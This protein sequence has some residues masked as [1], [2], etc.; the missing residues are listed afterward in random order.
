MEIMNHIMK[1]REQFQKWLEPF[2]H[3]IEKHIQQ[4]KTKYRRNGLL[5]CFLVIS[6]AG[7]AFFFSSNAWMPDTTPIT[8]SK[9]GESV[10][11]SE[12]ITAEPKR[13]VYS[14]EQKKMEI[15]LEI[16]NI[17]N[18]PDTQLYYSAFEKPQNKMLDVQVMFQEKGILV[19]EVSGISRNFHAL[20]L[21]ISSYAPGSDK[22]LGE[23][24]VSC[25]YR[26]VAKAEITEKDPAGYLSASIQ[27]DIDLLNTQ[28][29]ELTEKI[30]EQEKEISNIDTTIQELEDSKSLK[31]SEEIKSIDAEIMKKQVDRQ[32]AEKKISDLQTSIQLLQTQ[33]QEK[34]GLL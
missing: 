21:L 25:D 20:S 4:Y 17:S 11:V 19:L 26:T 15:E 23:A 31:T 24:S 7:Y 33:I 27:T 10:P 12:G 22:P 29:T 13:W 5:Y 30:A 8:A 9:L 34:E 1:S 28:V 3:R 2:V 16:L 32:S 18:R 14:P 6:L